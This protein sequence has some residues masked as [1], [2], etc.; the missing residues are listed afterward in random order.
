MSKFIISIVMKY[1]QN[2]KIETENECDMAPTSAN[3]VAREIS[4]NTNS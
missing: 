2:C 1:H 4:F 3:I